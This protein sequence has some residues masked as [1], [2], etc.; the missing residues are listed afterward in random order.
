MGEGW[1]F[2]S[3]VWL[4]GILHYWETRKQGHVRTEGVLKV[5]DYQPD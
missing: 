2:I 1:D 3:I 5:R 4:V